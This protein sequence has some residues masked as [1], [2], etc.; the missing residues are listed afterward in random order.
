MKLTIIHLWVFAC[1]AYG[2]AIV[3]AFQGRLTA[4]ILFAMIYLLVLI[5]TRWIT[6][7][8]A[9]KVHSS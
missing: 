5:S 6:N 9:T 1:V 3:L 7:N 4:S 2:F 8:G